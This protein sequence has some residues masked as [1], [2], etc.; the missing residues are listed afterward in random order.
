MVDNEDAIREIFERTSQ[1]SRE[2]VEWVTVPI[3]GDKRGQ[4]S[5]H[6]G[7]AELLQIG[8]CHFLLT[9]AHVLREI[10]KENERPFLLFP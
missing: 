5:Q 10:R 3:A 2:F 4:Y 6:R 9:A 8:D 7:T 1:A